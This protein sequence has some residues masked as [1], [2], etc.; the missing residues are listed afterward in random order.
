MF[1]FEIGSPSYTLLNLLGLKIPHTVL[2]L[3]W[4][5]SFKHNFKKKGNNSYRISS[6]SYTLLNLCEEEVCIENL[7]DI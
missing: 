4:G 1:H 6:P 3:A 7:K 5:E 2:T